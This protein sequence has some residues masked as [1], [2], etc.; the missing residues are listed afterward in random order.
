[1][2]TM[3]SNK[4]PKSFCIGCGVELNAAFLGEGGD[5]KPKPDDFTICVYCGTV[6]GYN[7]DLTL[8]R[9]S[10]GEEAEARKDEHIQTLL[11]RR[12]EFRRTVDPKGLA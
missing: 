2:E 11:E 6:M 7:E 3:Q 1:M 5:V 8:R 4:M 10:E 12:E 9:L